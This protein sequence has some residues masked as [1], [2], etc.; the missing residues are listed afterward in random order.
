MDS[1]DCE[2]EADSGDCD[3]TV[4]TYHDVVVSADPC[5]YGEKFHR[6]KL[7]NCHITSKFVSSDLNP[8][9][10]SHYIVCS[11]YFN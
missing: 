4:V 7:V 2:I 6:R 11:C 1:G 8:S 10:A 3:K 9:K 5:Q